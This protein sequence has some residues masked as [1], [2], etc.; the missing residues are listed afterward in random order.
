MAG[1]NA[2]GSH[3][4]L[5]G[6]HPALGRKGIRAVVGYQ[7]LSLR[8]SVAPLVAVQARF[9]RAQASSVR[10]GGPAAITSINC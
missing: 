3:C 2:Q 5:S 7:P 9:E 4:P 1:I 8:A 6:G 10:N